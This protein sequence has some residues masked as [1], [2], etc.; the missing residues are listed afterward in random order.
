MVSR[1]ICDGR[2]GVHGIDAGII[3]IEDMNTGESREA[4]KELFASISDPAEAFQ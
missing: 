3:E 4:N 2:F 1:L